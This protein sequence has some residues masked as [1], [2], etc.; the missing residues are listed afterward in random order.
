MGT[1]IGVPLL[2]AEPRVRAAVLGLAGG[3]ALTA[4]ARRI[5][6]PIQFLLQWDDHLVP[7][8]EGRALFEAFA[9]AEKALHANPGRHAEVPAFE[10]EDSARFLARH[11]SHSRPSTA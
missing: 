10:L 9:S 3:D 6:V 1:F 7:R 4:P 8:A 2:A 11:L 5:T